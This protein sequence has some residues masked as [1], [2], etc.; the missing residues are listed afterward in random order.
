MAKK[1]HE[2]YGNEKMFWHAPTF[3]TYHQSETSRKPPVD[4]YGTSG[5]PNL[6][7][8]RRG[9]HER[10]EAFDR[11]FMEV[12]LLCQPVERAM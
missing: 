4:F 7:P 2:A 6:R 8:G 5:N 11:F 9:D 1:S 3:R 10:T 12:R